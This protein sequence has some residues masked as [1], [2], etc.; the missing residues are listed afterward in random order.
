MHKAILAITLA[1][2]LTGVA[3]AETAAPKFITP[4]S[5][6]FVSSRVVGLDVYD[7]SNHDIGKI[8]DIVFDQSM[9]VKGYIL[10]VGGFL[11]LGERYVA[12]DPSSVAVKFDDNDKKWHANMN[13]TS[14]QLKSA[15]EF[16][17][18]GRWNSSKS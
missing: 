12:V 13:A 9:A 5:N 11:G 3:F 16:K 18:T 15:P 1:T 7:N 2:A 4:Q 14:D 6:D 10:S 17:Y 8:Q